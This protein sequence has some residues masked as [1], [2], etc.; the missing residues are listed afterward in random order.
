M[1]AGRLAR[2][3]A[4][5]RAALARATEDLAGQTRPGPD[6]LPL[7]PPRLM[8]SVSGAANVEWFLAAGGA[9]AED[10]ASA[11]TRTGRSV[12]GLVRVLDFGCGCGRVLRHLAEWIDRVELH[13]CDA[14]AAL[15]GWS[16]RHLPFARVTRNRPHPPLP[17]PDRHFGLIWALSVF[18][19]LPEANERAWLAELARVL[20]PGGL[21]LVTL[22][23]AANAVV[24]GAAEGAAFARGER[25]TVGAR[26]A[27]SNDCSAF[28][29]E[30][31]VREVFA[32]GWRLL[33][34]TPSGARGNPPQD[35]LLLERPGDQ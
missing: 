30:R 19:H 13:G 17:F 1:T 8:R 14:D 23:G 29:P 22:H 28:H 34:W 11:L 33:E 25:V 9:A 26:R 2:L 4:R 32:A 35:R 7:P 27:G 15:A 5:G 10:L 12:D 21:L 6:G 24:L 20:R 18:T 16:A 3:R 31:Y